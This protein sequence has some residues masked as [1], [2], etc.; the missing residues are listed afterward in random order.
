MALS[1]VLWEG[2]IWDQSGEASDV[3][4]P[5]GVPLVLDYAV[6]VSGTRPGTRPGVRDPSGRIA[7][8]F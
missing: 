5:G 1:L 6:R 7:L 8:L 4:H 3:T 2:R